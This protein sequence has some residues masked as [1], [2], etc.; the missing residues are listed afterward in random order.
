M[1]RLRNVLWKPCTLTLHLETL[2]DQPLKPLPRSRRPPERHQQLDGRVPALGAPPARRARPWQRHRREAARPQRGARACFGG[3][4]TPWGQPAAVLHAP[5]HAPLRDAAGHLACVALVLAQTASPP[6][7]GTLHLCTRTENPM[8][9]KG[10]KGLADPHCET[11][12][13]SSPNGGFSL[14]ISAVQA[15]AGLPHRR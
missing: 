10:P 4:P 2:T 6:Q 14:T 15:Q 13:P 5:N 9:S 7:D 1:Q 8:E 3:P 11:S 12:Q